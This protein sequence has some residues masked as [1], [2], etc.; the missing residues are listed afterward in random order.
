MVIPC[1]STAWNHAS[2]VNRFNSTAVAPRRW[3]ARM[4]WEEM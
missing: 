4:P 3:W 2:G 1:A